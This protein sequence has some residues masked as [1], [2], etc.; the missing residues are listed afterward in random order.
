MAYAGYE[1]GADL[2]ITILVLM[3]WKKPGFAQ[4]GGNER[5]T[6]SDGS[7]RCQSDSNRCI[8]VLQTSPL[9]LGYG[10]EHELKITGFSTLRK[11]SLGW[12][13]LMLRTY[14]HPSVFLQFTEFAFEDL[15]SKATVLSIP[16]A[17]GL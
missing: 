17:N 11:G 1:F 4:G 9:P 15:Q 5:A 13:G 14:S 7:L 2:R 10:T 16:L 12:H 8:K 6:L 3:V